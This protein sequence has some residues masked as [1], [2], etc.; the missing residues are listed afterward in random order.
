[1][2][3]KH[4]TWSQCILFFKIIMT[5]SCIVSIHWESMFSDIVWSFF[6][7]CASIIQFF[8]EEHRT[9][10]NI[11]PEKWCKYYIRLNYATRWIISTWIIFKTSVGDWLWF[12]IICVACNPWS[13]QWHSHHGHFIVPGALA[14]YIAWG[15]F[16]YNLVFTNAIFIIVLFLYS[17][18]YKRLINTSHASKTIK[19]VAAYNAMVYFIESIILWQIRCAHRFPYAFRWNPVIVG[20]LVTI[21]A[22]IWCHLFTKNTSVSRNSI[23]KCLP[24]S[25]TI[26][27]SLDSASKCS[28]CVECLT[29]LDME[30]SFSE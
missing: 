6:F 27:F 8:K 15:N 2:L 12:I 19:R 7:A 13:I 26:A 25:H 20:I 22:F 28:V 9:I 18:E 4:S 10:A 24:S 23:I 16:S 11:T 21:S 3:Q 30:S 14:L 17:K 5:I 1:M 29:S